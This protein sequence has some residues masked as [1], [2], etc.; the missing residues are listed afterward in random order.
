MV[1]GWWDDIDLRNAGHVYYYYDAAGSRLI[2]SFVEAPLYSVSTASLTFQMIF[3]PD[4]KILAQYGLMDPGTSTLLS[5]TV[6]IQNSTSDDG[7]TVVYNAAYM[8]DNMAIEYSTQNWLSTNPTG[9]IIEP[10]SE[11][12]VQVGFDATDLED[13]AYSGLIVISSNDPD[14]PSH[15]IDV[16]MTVASWIC[17]DIDGNGEVNIAD[18]VYVVAYSFESGPPPPVMSA[19]DADGSGEVN[20]ADIVMIVEYM[21]AEGPQP[22]CGQ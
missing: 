21:F 15:Q 4:G 17:V 3:T 7:L 8:H 11:E 16:T 18:L 9:G 1:A 13:G 10:L 5:G 12:V 20:I 6:G 14:Y 2:V 19:A 22:T